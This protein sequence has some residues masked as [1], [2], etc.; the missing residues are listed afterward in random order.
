MTALSK[1]RLSTISKS[2]IFWA[3][4]VLVLPL[5]AQQPISSDRIN[6]TSDSNSIS[7]LS[8]DGE[9]VFTYSGNVRLTQ[10]LIELSGRE[11]IVRMNSSTNEIVSALITGD[12]VYFQRSTELEAKGSE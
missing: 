7:G 6:I 2:F 9:R 11:A 1:I 5:S 12:P 10:G 3:A 8:Q 4:I